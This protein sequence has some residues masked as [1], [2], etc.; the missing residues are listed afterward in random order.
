M[1][2][3]VIDNLFPFYFGKVIFLLN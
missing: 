1:A 3:V 2:N